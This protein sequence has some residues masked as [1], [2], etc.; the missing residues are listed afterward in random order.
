MIKRGEIKLPR[1][2]RHE[3]WDKGR[4]ASLM[5]TI[6][7]DLP[8]GI[9][10]VLTVGEEEKFESR[11]LETAP[12]SGPRVLEHLLDGQQRLTALWRTLHN[13]YEHFTY[14]VYL[15]EWD[16]HGEQDS[17]TLEVYQWGRFMRNGQRYPLWCD[18]P[19][20]C[21][22]RGL[23]PT[24]LLKPED[25]Q[26][27]ID[28]WIS[29]ATQGQRPSDPNELES[30]FEW[31]K[32]ISDRVKDLRSTVRNYNLP[33]LALPSSTHQQTALDVFIN[34]N[35]NSK[36]LSTYDIIV[37]QV[38]SVIG[39]SLHE[40]QEGLNERQPEVKHYWDLSYLILNS[41]ALLQ[42]KL[43]NQRGLAE[44]NKRLLVQNW[45][46][47]ELGLGS[48]AR[49]LAGEGILDKQRLP[50]NAVLAVIAALYPEIPDRG[51]A[52]GV[53]EILLRKYLWSAFFTD[54]YENSAASKAYQDHQALK[55][56]INGDTKADG[57][58]YT[59]ADVPA[60]NRL[61]HPLATLEEL[62]TVG[63]PKRDTIRGRG[64]LAVA[65][66]LGAR[67]FATG[68]VMTRESLA[69]REYHHLFP[70]ALLAEAGIDGDLSLNCALISG[71]TNRNIGRKEPLRYLKERYK[72]VDEGHVNDRLNSHLIPIDELR[73]GGYEGIP[74][75]STRNERITSDFRAFL[76]KRGELMVR[77]AGMLA[78]GRNPT[79]GQVLEAL[80]ARA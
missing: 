20:D 14:F 25:I 37:A 11:Y 44:M 23:V 79:A 35:T 76:Q 70:A 3:A 74:D 52:R 45:D 50:T 62:L 72:W 1:F 2:Q 65:S 31:K 41:S 9:T 48:M 28:Q 58:R 40:L 27:E 29:E 10:L 80:N 39:Q 18:R 15:P 43:P 78:D 64:V 66:R 33:Y 60:L 36:P 6:A 63:W 17:E 38:E 34:M 22:K 59:E 21:L 46:K 30:F 57:T 61:L 67:D 32:S 8:L 53:A 49:F 73:T 42:D 56:V 47:L 69:Q 19:E 77:A 54:R 5:R 71:P 4:I 75:E 24:N 26:A 51:D 7:E 12:D 55:R 13:N 68:Q 16:K